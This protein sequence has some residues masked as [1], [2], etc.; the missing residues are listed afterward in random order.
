MII[1]SLFNQLGVIDEHGIYML[2]NL[3]DHKRVD[4]SDREHSG[5]HG[6]RQQHAL[7]QQADS[8][9]CDGQVVHPDDS[10]H[11][12]AG[13]QLWWRGRDF[14]IR[15]IFRISTAALIWAPAVW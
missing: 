7:H 5:S 4:L 1:S 12:Q 8:G 15:F 9:A 10:P 3:P 13:R 11:Q 2:S 14:G 6:E